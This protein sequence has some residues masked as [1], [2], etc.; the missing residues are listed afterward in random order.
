MLHETD[1][2]AFVRAVGRKEHEKTRRVQR[3]KRSLDGLSSSIYVGESNRRIAE[4]KSAEDGIITGC[5]GYAVAESQRMNMEL[6]ESRCASLQRFVAMCVVFHEMGTRVQS[7]FPAHSCGYLGYR[8]DRTHSMLRVATTASPVSGAD[9]RERMERLQSIH[10]IENAV[11]VI[12]SAWYR[13]RRNETKKF[14]KMKNQR[15][16][17][18][19]RSSGTATMDEDGTE[20]STYSDANE[21]SD[22]APPSPIGSPITPP[23]SSPKYLHY[24]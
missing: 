18:S 8:V 3:S 14:F 16:L 19:R 10:V 13:Y 1:F 6:Y 2:D 23:S 22:G 9:V 15:K 4:D 5:G 21:N 17:I 11:K 20:N 7:F 12:S 24:E